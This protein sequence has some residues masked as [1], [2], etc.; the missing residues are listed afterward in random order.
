MINNYTTVVEFLV[1]KTKAL[2]KFFSRK[3]EHANVILMSYYS[4]IKWSF[5][6]W[7]YVYIV[8]VKLLAK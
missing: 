8:Y 1:T 2:E 5:N 6:F 3:W 7:I 4:L